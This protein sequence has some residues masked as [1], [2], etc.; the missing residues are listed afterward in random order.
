MK[1]GKNTI[2]MNENMEKNHRNSKVVGGLIVI[3]AGVLI[4]LNQMGFAFP[5]F[6]L[7]WKMILIAVGFVM[8]IKHNFQKTSAYVLIAIGTVFILNDFFPDIIETRFFW[9]ILI[10][11]V[12]ISMIFK[13]SSSSNKKAQTEDPQEEDLSELNSE[14]YIKS[15]SLFSGITKKVVSKNFKGATISSVFGGNEI[16]L[17]QADFTGE[18]II[19]ITCVFGGVTLIVP[20]QWKVKSDLTSVFGGIDD[21]RPI[22]VLE[23]IS[24]D[25]LLV[26]KGAC[27]FGGIE[28]H[29]YN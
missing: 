21:Q 11:G 17:S 15:A 28:I 18:A 26:L 3:A 20:S 25:K 2:V 6:L 10:I 4:L 1:K 29:S 19:D 9:P 23:S 22:M 14:D 12:G 13:N 5:P 16:N 7:S 8:L 24:E 27:V